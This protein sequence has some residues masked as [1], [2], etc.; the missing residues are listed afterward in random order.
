MRSYED[1]LFFQYFA[2][3]CQLWVCNQKK[4]T[5]YAAENIAKAVPELK[6]HAPATPP[7]PPSAPTP[8]SPISE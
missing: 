4:T 8:H 7:P 2:I 5:I 1:S 6:S 3:F